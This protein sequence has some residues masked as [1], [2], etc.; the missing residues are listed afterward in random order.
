M[1][2]GASSRSRPQL[3]PQLD[4][5]TRLHSSSL[6]TP[7]AIRDIQPPSNA[8]AA[9][10]S[11]SDSE[12]NATAS[13]R[14]KSVQ[15]SRSMSNPFPSLFSGKKKKHTPNRSREFGIIPQSRDGYNQ[16]QASS[17][18]PKR[19]GPSRS[20]EFVTGN[21]MTCDSLMRWPKEQNVYRCTICSTINDMV[22]LSPSQTSG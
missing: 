2:R 9:D 10:S 6:A 21:C 14:S 11:E 3:P 16:R 12:F 8:L 15:H 13:S 18:P 17:S 7:T 4:L 22:P 19:P 1:T 5:V 20:Q